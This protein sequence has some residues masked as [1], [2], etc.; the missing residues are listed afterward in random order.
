MSDFYIKQNDTSPAIKVTCR[1]SDNNP[2]VV[3]GATVR[4]HMRLKSD[5]TV[6][7]DDAGSVISGTDG[8]I[9]YAWSAG[10]TDTAGLYEAEF[11]LTYTD[12]TIETF[13]NDGYISVTV[14]DDIA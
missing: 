1:D 4:F 13:P 8:T 3:T 10:D 5:G 6:K 2:I 9:Q 7:V 11:E 14:T 12:T